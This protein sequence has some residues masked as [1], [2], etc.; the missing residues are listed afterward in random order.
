[1]QPGELRGIM[2]GSA[3]DGSLLALIPDPSDLR[4]VGAGTTASG[5][6]ADATGNVYAVDVGGHK[7]RKYIL[8]R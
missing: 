2:V 8:R 7:V 1:V 4:T 3:I 6:A 5:I